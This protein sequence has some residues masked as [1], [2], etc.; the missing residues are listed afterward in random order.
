M[1]KVV[2]LQLGVLTVVVAILGGILGVRGAASG[3]IGGAAYILPNLLFAIRLRVL[4]ASGRG[5]APGFMV[6]QLLK[7]AGTIAFLAI[8]QR[9]YELHWLAMLAGLFAA[10]KANL[11]AFLLKT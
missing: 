2:L 8:A 7:L 4:S 6:G 9:Y 3:L 5:S 11:F 10:L 1:L